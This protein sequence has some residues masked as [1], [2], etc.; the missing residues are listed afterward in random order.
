ML[1]A[2][3]CVLACSDSLSHLV[4]PREQAATDS[5]VPPPQLVHGCATFD[6]SLSGASPSIAPVATQSCGPI[7]PVVLRVQR[8]SQ[9]STLMLTLA[10]RNPGRLRLHGPL[11]LSFRSD[12]A[13]VTGSP[14]G[15][16]LRFALSELHAGDFVTQAG[17]RAAM[18]CLTTASNA[19][20]RSDTTALA[21]G[22][23]S[24]SRS[25]RIVIPRSAT[26]LRLTVHAGGVWIFTVPR[27][28]PHSTPDSIIRE[29]V[30][31]SHFAG[32][33]A[34]PY[35]RDK[36]LVRFKTSASMED[37]QAAIDAINGIVIG[38]SVGDY[39][40]RI[41]VRKGGHSSAEVV[42]AMS[43]MQQQPGVDG[44]T[45]DVPG[46]PMSNYLRP[47][48][49]TGFTSWPLNP[50]DAAGLNW[51]P[52]AVAAPLAWGCSVGDTMTTI[53]VVDDDFDSIPDL[54][55]NIKSGA[56]YANLIID[57]VRRYPQSPRRVTPDSGQ[58]LVVCGQITGQAMWGPASAGSAHPWQRIFAAN[59]SSAS[60]RSSSR[61]R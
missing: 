2:L 34:S 1:A 58:P 51:G 13:I 55:P 28:P 25:L 20:S 7:A 48:D 23:T 29:S 40:I 26:N 46:G 22:A 16:A 43:V 59:A 35:A 11:S 53:G 37:R 41:P 36:L 21:V 45:L 52:T 54:A 19:T 33:R 44:V 27:A 4:A 24:P 47:T 5:Q 42:H 31:S 32:G 50:A 18:R 39:Y 14:N 12:S 38:G 56:Y 8:G 6:I 30:D 3:L 49:S 60:R 17:S 15:S 10:I 9:D 61:S 57:H